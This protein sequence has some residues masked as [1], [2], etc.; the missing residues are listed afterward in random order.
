M[1]E[2][3]FTLCSEYDKLP[4]SCLLYEPDEEPKGIVQI[5]HGMCEHKER[6][7]DF[8]R[9]LC[10]KG[11][12][13]FCHD[14]R[15]H[16]DSLKEEGH[17]G[18]FNDR[19]GTAVV[20]DSVMM[21]KYLKEQY[22]NLPLILFGH[23]MGS[24]IVRCF[25]REHDELVDKLIVCGSPAKNSMV[26]MAIFIAKSERIWLG[27]FHRSKMLTYLSTGKGNKRFKSEGKCAWLSKNRANVEAYLADPKCAYKFTANGF[28]NLFK[29]MKRTYEK[30][31]YGVKNPSM[32]IH[33]VAGG[34]DPVIGNEVSWL[35]G[36]EFLREAGYEKVSGKLYEGMRHEI[37]Q[38]DGKEEVYNDLLSFIEG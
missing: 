1:T 37:L 16:G 5:E 12:V 4:L 30:K 8:M 3:T 7:A 17:L 15:G 28:E 14:H 11:Y 10:E 32:P 21:T 19:N 33:F 22:P 34:D 23:S 27:D 36:I 38:E 24:M 29:I 25:L 13:A 31:G 2:K 18:Y 9:Y 35:K 20:D 6:Y 26:G